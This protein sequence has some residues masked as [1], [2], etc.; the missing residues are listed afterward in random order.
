[1]GGKIAY[2]ETENVYLIGTTKSRESEFIDE[3]QK[4]KYTLGK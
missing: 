3:Q 1:L 4:T 2:E